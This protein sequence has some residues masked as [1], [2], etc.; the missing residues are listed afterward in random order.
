[1]SPF[2][3][4]FIKPVSKVQWHI[5]TGIFIDGQRA[6]GVLDCIGSFVNTMQ[7]FLSAKVPNLKND[8]R[9]GYNNKNRVKKRKL[10][11]QRC[12]GEKNTHQRSSP[13]PPVERDVVRW[14]ACHLQN[15]LCQANGT[16]GAFDLPRTLKS[17]GSPSEDFWWQCGSLL[18]GSAGWL[19][20]EPCK[21]QACINDLH[22][23]WIA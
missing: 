14:S 5:W 16:H 15:S 11:L 7:N 18:N 3:G 21:M 4:S 22:R 12:S 17:Q 19:S 20:F 2:R 13:S 8:I 6:A 23:L 10:S 9:L 1:M